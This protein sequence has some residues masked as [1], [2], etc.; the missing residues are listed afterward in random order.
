VTYL[1]ATI[2]NASHDTPVNMYSVVVI[3]PDGE[4]VQFKPISDQLREWMNTFANGA[5]PD[6]AKYNQGL[7]LLNGNQDLSPTRRERH[8]LPDLPNSGFPR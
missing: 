5:S 8:G 6:S 1:A 3:T 7:N 2:N 4:Q